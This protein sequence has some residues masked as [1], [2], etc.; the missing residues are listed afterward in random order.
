MNDT[1]SFPLVVAA[2]MH[3]SAE[4]QVRVGFLGEA[5]SESWVSTAFSRHY[6]G[7]RLKKT[8]SLALETDVWFLSQP[9]PRLLEDS[10]SCFDIHHTFGLGLTSEEQEVRYIRDAY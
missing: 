7:T 9:R 6:L 4:N 1:R 5:V 8:G 10:N 3:P 2:A